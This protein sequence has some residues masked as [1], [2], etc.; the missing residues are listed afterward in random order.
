MV[1]WETVSYVCSAEMSISIQVHKISA[2]P[3]PHEGVAGGVSFP[4]P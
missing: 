1:L 2:G 4:K 3:Y